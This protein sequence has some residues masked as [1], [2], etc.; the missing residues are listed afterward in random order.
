M[1]NDEFLWDFK[2]NNLFLLKINCFE[3]EKYINRYKI[4][5]CFKNVLKSDEK[6]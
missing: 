1:K 5:V 3:I 4:N 2:L 6:I